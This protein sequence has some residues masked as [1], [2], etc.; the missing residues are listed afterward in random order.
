MDEIDDGS[1]GTRYVYTTRS[2]QESGITIL[3]YPTPPQIHAVLDV[4]RGNVDVDY[5]LNS[6]GSFSNLTA[7]IE[8]RYSS[9]SEMFNTYGVTSDDEPLTIPGL[10]QDQSYNFTITKTYTEPVPHVMSDAYSENPHTVQATPPDPTIQVFDVAEGNVRIQYQVFFD[11]LFDTANIVVAGIEFVENA[12]RSNGKA[13]GNVYDTSVTAGTSYDFVLEVD[14]DAGVG[15][16]PYDETLVNTVENRMVAELPVAGILEINNTGNNQVTVNYDA[17]TDYTFT[18]GTVTLKYRLSTSQSEI[19]VPPDRIISSLSESKEYTFILYQAYTSPYTITVTDTETHTMPTLPTAGSVGIRDS[20]ENQVT[21]TFNYGTDGSVDGSPFTG[22]KSVR[23]TGPSSGTVTSDGQVLTLGAGTYTFTVSKAY[24]SPY[25]ITRTTAETHIMPTLPV[26]GSV[27]IRDSGENQ[28]TMTFNYGTDGS[29]DGSP[30]TGTKSVTYTGPSSGTVTTYGQVLT[31]GVGT[32]TFTVSKVYD[33]PYGLTRTTTET[34]TMP[35]KPTAGTV[36]GAQWTTGTTVQVTYSP[37]IGGSYGAIGTSNTFN[38]TN[39]YID[40]W[41]DKAVT[42]VAD[43]DVDVISQSSPYDWN[44]SI[45]VSGA[46]IRFKLREVYSTPYQYTATSTAE[47]PSSGYTIPISSIDLASVFTGYDNVRHLMGIH[48]IDDSYTR[49][50][51]T[52]FFVIGED[53]ASDYDRIGASILRYQYTHALSS[54]NSNIKDGVFY[55]ASDTGFEGMPGLTKGYDNVFDDDGDPDN[56]LT[57]FAF[58]STVAVT[59]RT[60]TYTTKISDATTDAY[61]SSNV[62]AIN[63]PAGSVFERYVKSAI[64]AD[65]S[66]LLI[67]SEDNAPANIYGGYVYLYK[68]SVTDFQYSYDLSKYDNESPYEFYNYG[69][70]C[71]L[72]ADGNTVLVAGHGNSNIGTAYIWEYDALDVSWSDTE[73]PAPTSATTTGSWYGWSC[74][75]SAD[76][77][78]AL[79]SCTKGNPDFDAYLWVKKA[80]GSGWVVDKQFSE[81]NLIRL[82]FSCALSGDGTVVLFTG[83]KLPPDIGG[84]AYIRSK[85]PNGNWSNRNL[86]MDNVNGAYGYACA[87]SADGKVALITGHGRHDYLYKTGTAWVWKFN[88][89]DWY[90]DASL[91]RQDVSSLYGI[92]CSL[93]ADGTIAMICGKASAANQNGQVYFWKDNGTSWSVI[94]QHDVRSATGRMGTDCSLSASGEYGIVTEQM[95]TIGSACNLYEFKLQEGTF[96]TGNVSV[97]TTYATYS[98][99]EN[100]NSFDRVL[101]W[102]DDIYTDLTTNDDTPFTN[103]YLNFG[104][105]FGTSTTLHTELNLS[106]SANVL[107]N[108]WM[109]GVTG[110]GSNIYSSVELQSMVETILSGKKIQTDYVTLSHVDFELYLNDITLDNAFSAIDGSPTT[111]RITNLSASPVNAVIVALEGDVYHAA[112]KNTSS[113]SSIFETQ[114]VGISVMIHFEAEDSESQTL[115]NKANVSQSFSKIVEPS[116]I[117]HSLANI[118]GKYGYLMHRG[119]INIENIRSLHEG[120]VDTSKPFEFSAYTIFTISHSYT[121]Y[122]GYPNDSRLFSYTYTEEASSVLND[123]LFSITLSSSKKIVLRLLGTSRMTDLYTGFDI[124]NERVTD[125][126]NSGYSSNAKI[127]LLYVS[128]KRLS[129]STYDFKLKLWDNMFDGNIYSNASVDVSLENVTSTKSRNYAASGTYDYSIGGNGTDA[130]DSSL[131]GV[132]FEHK[133]YKGIIDDDIDRIARK[134]I[135]DYSGVN[136][137]PDTVAWIEANGQEIYALFDVT[138]G[139]TSRWIRDNGYTVGHRRVVLISRVH[140]NNPF[141][142]ENITTEGSVTIERENYGGVWD[143]HIETTF[144]EPFDYTASS[145]PRSTSFPIIQD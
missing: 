58:L 127:F 34:H 69:M 121:E 65:G 43:Y 49:F 41:V 21:V 47:Y 55:Q 90:K 36:T 20:G 89:T 26:A 15:Q 18:P 76:G 17:G 108:V 116:T 60:L 7:N 28:V 87:L 31:L 2:N 109:F 133:L 142:S 138:F 126:Y 128:V 66:T 52:A 135:A 145:Y 32:Y 131:F 86:S 62:L 48:H 4:G 57:E 75:L 100:N 84:Y 83:H 27:G 74:A 14:Y 99:V 23:Y 103:T 50:S 24:T 130:F 29:V 11:G 10:T 77:S 16:N 143:F 39:R 70:T 22:T 30:F 64:S 105:V 96:T 141:Y 63:A 59:T 117:N 119:C 123:E 88:G 139:A 72:S 19:D 144:T 113:G 104:H 134:K 56:A 110:T 118:D 68:R 81:T 25:T 140:P 115:I 5:D 114:W 97:D 38:L 91:S 111:S 40:V 107:D 102:N 92:S 71:A 124:D 42:A 9:N 13:E 129:T 35:T 120:V 132:V 6:D 78:V 112:Y 44:N 61:T 37:G 12:N 3:N 1:G 136:P 98:N 45:F 137:T 82:G 33:D 101:Y 46:V 8:V 53:N 93:S 67:T 79:V 106:A 73:L 54:W 51:S 95:T 94:S 125:P 122:D 80:D 85:L